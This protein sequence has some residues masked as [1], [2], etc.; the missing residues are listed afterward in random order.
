MVAV[1]A[2]RWPQQLGVAEQVCFAGDVPNP[3]VPR[4]IQSARLLVFPTWC[5]SFGL[6]LAEA[7]AMGAP[8]VA[9]DIP[10]CREVGGDAAGYYRPGD[11]GLMADD[12]WRVAG[13]PDADLALAGGRHAAR[14]L[15]QLARQRCG[16]ARE[17]RLGRGRGDARRSRSWCRPWTRNSTCPSAWTAWPGPTRSFVVDSF[18]AIAPSRSPARGVRTSSSTA[19]KTTRVR[20]TGR[21][22]R[23]RCATTWVLIVD[24]DERVTPALRAELAA[25]FGPEP[26]RAARGLLRNPPLHLPRSLDSATPAGTRAWNLRRVPLRPLGRY[27]DRD[28]HEHLVLDGPRAS[29]SEDLLHHDRA[30]PGGGCR[31]PQPVFDARSRGPRK[32]EADSPDRARLPGD[33]LASPVQCNASSG[34]GSARRAPPSRGAV[35]VHVS[36]LRRASS[37]AA[38]GLALCVFHAFQEFMVGL[39][40]RRVAPAIISAPHEAGSAI[41]SLG[42]D[43]GVDVP[44]P[45]R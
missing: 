7:L 25:F 5:E 45:C 20:R 23:C 3:Q 33:L 11:A 30:R 31:A 32:A 21:S 24:A 2:S 12:N 42:A 4:L 28:V 9:A 16:G 36:S 6:P 19:S 29:S 1:A 14:R 27:D 44:A 40:A 15:L 35:R 39:E 41:P 13:S 18:S 37:T 26:R 34:N 8:A 22:T 10:A 43:A 17:P 38:L